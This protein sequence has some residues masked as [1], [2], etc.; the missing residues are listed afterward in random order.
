M[1]KSTLSNYGWV[2][3]AV[4]VLSVIIALAT[5][6]GQ[7]IENGVRSTTEG[8]FNTGQNAMNTAFGDLGVEIKD[9]EFQKGYTGVGESSESETVVGSATFKY[10]TKD[11]CNC[12]GN[13]HG[14]YISIEPVTLTWKELQLEENGKKY[15]YYASEISD[16]TIGYS[17][18]YFCASLTNITIPNTVT[19]I[20]NGA[21]EGGNILDL[22]Y[23]GTRAQWNK[24]SFDKNWNQECDRITVTCTDGTI[25]IPAWEY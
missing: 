6:F 11:G 2:V 19:S 21:F 9:Q 4:L 12:I 24:I 20:K 14:C 5:P 25:T 8:L 10:K 18:F 13:M 22:N 1:D 17:A 3:I 15:G 7:Y 23:N 16:T